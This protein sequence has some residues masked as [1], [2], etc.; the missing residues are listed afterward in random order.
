MANAFPHAAVTNVIQSLQN[1]VAASEMETRE[2][3]LSALVRPVDG[4]HFVGLG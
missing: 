3:A 4:C 2:T 1:P